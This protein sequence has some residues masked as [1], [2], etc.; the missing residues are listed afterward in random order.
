MDASARSPESIR[1]VSK[2][3]LD[4]KPPK[5]AIRFPQ[6]VSGWA[7]H[8]ERDSSGDASLD[9]KPLDRWAEVKTTERPPS[10]G[11]PAL[12]ADQRLVSATSSPSIN[13]AT[14]RESNCCAAIASTTSASGCRSGAATL[15]SATNGDEGP[16]S[17]A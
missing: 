7:C 3:P 8:A 6:R 11:W 10:K 14:P 16:T 9:G 17:S 4:K 2:S 15:L 5:A 13:N 12:S 1:Y